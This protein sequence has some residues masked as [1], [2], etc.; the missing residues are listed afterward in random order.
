MKI[1]PVQGAAVNQMPG[2]KSDAPPALSARDKAIQAFMKPTT[3]AQAEAQ[4]PQTQSTPVKNPS[5]VSPEE[6][7]ALAKKYSASESTAQSSQQDTNESAPSAESKVSSE[8]LSSQ[9]AA[10]ARKERAIRQREQQ[11]R[12][13]EADM[14]KKSALAPEPAKPTFDE[15]NYVPKDRL[16]QD[17]FA[18]LN[19][20]GLTYDQLTELAMKAPA[21]EQL[22]MQ[23]ELRALREEIKTLKGETENTKKSFEQ[24]QQQQNDQALGLMRQ[25]TRKL[26]ASDPTFEMIK[27]TPGAIN[28]V[29]NLIEKTYYEDGEFLS[30]EEAAQQ[31]EEYLADEAIKYARLTKIQQRLQPKP[32]TPAAKQSGQSPQQQTQLKTLTNSVQGSRPLTRRERAIL[33]FEGNLKK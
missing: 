17:P 25:E 5:Q 7:S 27:A 23:N 30:V 4:A 1:E 10:L 16:T 11:L 28:E 33:A 31:V 29:V 12:A 19:E 8:P 6:F 24:S 3:N 2:A 21:P 13:K 26:V 9:Y 18:V 15:K 14:A 20:L 32:T 22:A